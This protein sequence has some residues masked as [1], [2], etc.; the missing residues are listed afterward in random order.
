MNYRNYIQYHNADQL[1][2]YPSPDLDFSSSV[3]SLRLDSSVKFAPWIYTKKKTVEKAI[4]GSCFLIV[5]KSE[6]NF[7]KYFLWSYFEIE[8]Y[9]IIG[10]GYYKVYGTGYDF[11]N[12]VLLNDL[13]DFSSFKDFC[14]NFGIGFQNIDK[15]IFCKT[16]ISLLPQQ[17]LPSLNPDEQN[18]E[19]VE[20]YARPTTEQYKDIIANKLSNRQIEI[21]QVLYHFPNSSA[22][23]IQLAEALNYKSYHGANRQIG[24]LGE[25]FYKHSGIEPPIYIDGEGFAYYYFIGEYRK[26]IGWIM[27]PEL[28]KALENLKL[29]TGGDILQNAYTDRLPT[30]IMPFE[31]KKFYEEGKV[32]EVFVN[33]YERNQNARLECIKHYGN[34]CQ[35][36]GF[37][38]ETFYGNT[39]K[40]SIQVHHIVPLAEIG[41]TYK[42]NPITDLVPLCPNCHS[43]VHSAK[44]A[45]SIETLRKL[46]KRN[47][48]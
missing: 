27:W 4:G 13:E 31:E 23:A 10:N 38:F 20:K 15:H 2:R 14:G 6:Q 24:A 46:I 44:P 32:T 43:V 5:G 17:N 35:G 16:L 48:T 39:V 21:L 1:G 8:D 26:K 29:V 30:E 12:P 11:A 41:K 25:A 45:L 34:I 40:I 42:V 22:T 28:K 19:E 36:C 18:D 9:E 7:K 47:E 3:N 37:D 33:R